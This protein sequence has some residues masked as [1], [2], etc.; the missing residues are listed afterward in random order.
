[1]TANAPRVLGSASALLLICCGS[2][3]ATRPASRFVDCAESCSR[4]G[5]AG[6]CGQTSASCLSECRAELLSTPDSCMGELSIAW[7][8][9]QRARWSCSPSNQIVARG[10]DDEWAALDAC[11][12]KAA[13]KTADAAVAGDG[14]A[15]GS[16]GGRTSS[17]PCLTCAFRLC[18]PQSAAWLDMG[19]A[20]RECTTA[21]DDNASCEKDCD[22]RHPD[23]LLLR[24]SFLV[25]AVSQCD[26]CDE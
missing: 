6:A 12:Q 20:L 11:T 14:A 1:M 21:C 5:E 25:C 9:A 23:E 10:C 26:V 16:C 4:V 19:R 13:P 15:A 7:D 22:T 8:C 2:D 3:P 18:C 24:Q 17:S